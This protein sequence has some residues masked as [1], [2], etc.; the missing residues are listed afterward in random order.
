[1]LEYPTVSKARPIVVFCPYSFFL[2]LIKS[3]EILARQIKNDEYLN[4]VVYPYEMQ[5]LGKIIAV[6]KGINSE[7]NKAVIIIKTQ[8]LSTLC[9]ASSSLKTVV[10]SNERGARSL[11]NSEM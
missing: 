10:P 6:L 9:L 2:L 4:V 8:F 7:K 1:M 11:A 3:A 5:K